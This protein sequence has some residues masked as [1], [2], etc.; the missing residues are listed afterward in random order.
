[1]IYDQK[2][3]RAIL[4]LNPNLKVAVV[5]ATIGDESLRS[6][7]VGGHLDLVLMSVESLK[8]WASAFEAMHRAG[9]LA[10]I[11]VDEA[12]AVVLW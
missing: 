12:H 11:V 4:K 2:R 6:Q 9:R 5:T 3:Q 7:I 1:M 8:T 10:H